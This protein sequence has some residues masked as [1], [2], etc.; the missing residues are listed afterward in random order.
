M[1]QGTRLIPLSRVKP[2]LEID[3]VEE[4]KKFGE[5]RAFDVLMEAQRYWDNMSRFRAERDRCKRYTYGD[6][7][8]DK[9]CV[10]GKYMTEEEYIES[11]GS[12]PLKNNLIRRLV[13]TVLGMTDEVVYSTKRKS[14]FSERSGV[15]AGNSSSEGL[16]SERSEHFSHHAHTAQNDAAKVQQNT[17]VTKRAARNIQNEGGLRKRTTTPA[18]AVSALGKELH[19]RKAKRTQTYYS[20]SYEGDFEIDGKIV[21]VRISTHPATGY[22]M[23]N[24]D[25][26][27]LFYRDGLEKRKRSG[28]YASR[29]KTTKEDLAIA[30][31]DFSVER[32]TD[33]SR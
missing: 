1:K 2:Q 11:Q 5:R 3:T 16:R 24:A 17:K 10:D 12:I 15:V 13:R 22:R 33:N 32:Q 23:G 29:K 26:D 9:I 28:N 8:S 19:L 21:H 4:S 30:Y 31:H 20:D 6:Q 7:W 18:Q 27:Q 14:T 25:A